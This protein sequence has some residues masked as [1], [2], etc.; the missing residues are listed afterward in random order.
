MEAY[1]AKYGIKTVPLIYY[2]K[3]R[4]FYDISVND[5]WHETFLQKLCDDYLELDCTLCSN[6]VPDEG[7]CL[8]VDKPLDIQVYKL[9]S[10]RFF[11]RETKL[12]D[13]GVVDLETLEAETQE[14]S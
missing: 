11:E 9:K 3:A 7:I 6:S 12:L 2:G 1:C 10:F 4:D 8:R 14:D 13:E 5:H